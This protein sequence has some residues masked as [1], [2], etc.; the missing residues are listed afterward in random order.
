MITENNLFARLVVN[1]KHGRVLKMK[2]KK[3]KQGRPA[4]KDRKIV[5]SI[6]IG[7]RV[8]PIKYKSFEKAAK[9]CDMKV[10]EYCEYCVGLETER[11]TINGLI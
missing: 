1:K 6:M 9:Y 5:K 11:I 10:S 8:D 3:R 7:F 2:T 4:I